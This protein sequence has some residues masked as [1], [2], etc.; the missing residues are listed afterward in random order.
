MSRP[1]GGRTQETITLEIRPHF[2]LNMLIDEFGGIFRRRIELPIGALV[3]N[4]EIS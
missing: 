1:G 3:D 2:A 4:F